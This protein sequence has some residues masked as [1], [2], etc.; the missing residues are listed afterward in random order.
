MKEEEE[1]EINQKKKNQF[2]I[3]GCCGCFEACDPCC[4]RLGCGCK[5]HDSDDRIAAIEN[6]RS[7]TDLPCLAL[8]ICFIIFL[9]SY[10]W[11]TAY[12][13]GDPDRLIRGVN[14]AGKIC[15]KD[16]PV[17]NLPYAFWPDVSE[18]R[19]KACTNDCNQATNTDYQSNRIYVNG[20]NAP[21]PSKLYIDKYCIPS[22]SNVSISQFDSISNEFQ[23]SMGDVE[24]AIPII[25]ASIGIAFIMS[26]LYIWLMKC[27]VG[28]LVWTTIGVILGGGLLLG[29]VLYESSDDDDLESDEQD[30]RKYASYVIFAITAIFFLVI[31]FA[32]NRIRIAIQVIKSAGRA[33]GDMPM[34]VFF[35]IGP[36]IVLIG[37]FLAWLYGT[38]YI[39]SAGDKELKATPSAYT[40]GTFSFASESGQPG[41]ESVGEE[42]QVIDYNDTIQEMFAPHFFLLL[43]VCQFAI[44]F[45]FTV[46]SGAVA[47]WYF[48]PRNEN[49]KKQRG[50]DENELPNNAVCKSCFRTSRYHLGT[51][52][53]AALIIAIIQF[54]RACVRYI[55]RQMKQTEKCEKLRKVIFCVIDCLLWC[56]E[57]CLD[58][59]SRNALIWVS[60][61]GDAFC[62]SV[63]GS[64]KIIWSNLVRVAVI[65]F[66]SAIVTNLG[67]IMVPLATTGICALILLNVDPYQDELGS[68]II[69]LIII[70]IISLA[71]AMMFLTVYDTAIDTV[72]LCF[73]IDEKH[74]AKSGQMLADPQLRNIVQKYEAQSKELAASVQRKG[75]ATQKEVQ[76]QNNNNNN[77]DVE[78]EA[79]I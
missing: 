66:F 72:F 29:Y 74:N 37:F 40:Q 67:K 57:C 4:R 11:G 60:I 64:F 23:R 75:G 24:T 43:W 32:R 76:A 22:F 21:Y 38:I 47:N 42:Y 48:T 70:F 45:T 39:F 35:P 28:V 52:I 5:D 56:L 10:V 59:V 78:E 51:V 71:I 18:F 26:F 36:I 2:D 16:Y 69:P 20:V 17:E 68:P 50:N 19:F 53:Y 73:L 33:I 61:Y 31:L 41:F 9:V 79:A 14:H 54:I 65:T 46:I 62:P 58:K 44:Y 49:G 63:C 6:K 25:G 8:F 30:Y 3:M 12:S 7:C 27:C 13:D 15:G 34:M 1:E 55:E 77:N